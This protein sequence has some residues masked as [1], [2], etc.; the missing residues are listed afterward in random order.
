M[1]ASVA[2]RGISWWAPQRLLTDGF[3]KISLLHRQSELPGYSENSFFENKTTPPP[4]AD[5][6]DGTVAG[7]FFLRLPRSLFPPSFLTKKR[8]LLVSCGFIV[9]CFSRHFA[10]RPRPCDPRPA[11][12]KRDHPDLWS[13]PPPPPTPNSTPWFRWSSCVGQTDR[14]WLLHSRP[15]RPPCQSVRW[16]ERGRAAGP[17]AQTPSTSRLWPL[18][19]VCGPNA[20]KHIVLGNASM[21]RYPFEGQKPLWR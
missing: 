17:D 12:R 19:A 1:R 21:P 5:S 8:S 10:F 13:A 2:P 9:A 18:Q 3:S 20:T 7:Y 15:F 14:G 11:P 4:P 16:E 6:R